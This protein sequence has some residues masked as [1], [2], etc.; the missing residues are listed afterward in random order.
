MIDADTMSGILSKHPE[1]LEEL[2]L[3]AAHLLKKLHTTEFASGDFSDARDMQ[4]KRVKTAF[5]MDII[6][7]EDKAMA[8]GVIDRIPYRNTFIH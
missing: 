1:R 3:K 7:A 6:S 4:R 2:S 8:D 5:E